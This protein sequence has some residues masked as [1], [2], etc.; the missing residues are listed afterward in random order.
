MGFALEPLCGLI[1]HAF[2][3]YNLNH[4]DRTQATHAR[5]YTTIVP[6][7]VGRREQRPRTHD[8]PRPCPTTGPAV[9]APASPSTSRPRHSNAA[10][11][12]TPTAAA[13]LSHATSRLHR[14]LHSFRRRQPNQQGG[15]GFCVFFL[16]FDDAARRHKTAAC[17][18]RNLQFASA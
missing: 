18:F 4:T 5:D 7:Y 10:T 2:A 6:R 13:A 8:A 17:M 12:A 15:S 16:L 14:L 3:P 9:H 11:P 1:H